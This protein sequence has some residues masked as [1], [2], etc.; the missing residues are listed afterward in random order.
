[1]IMQ[2]NIAIKITSMSRRWSRIFSKVL[3]I[4][5]DEIG[6]IDDDEFCGVKK[7]E[8]DMP[9]FEKVGVEVGSLSVSWMP[10]CIDVVSCRC[11]CRCRSGKPE[12]V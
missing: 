4:G 7:F 12:F 1:M 8:Q 11:R 2:L 10:E 3:K 6:K 9:Q 5:I